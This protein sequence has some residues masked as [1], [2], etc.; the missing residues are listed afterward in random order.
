MTTRCVSSL[1]SV[2]GTAFRHAPF[3]VALRFVTVRR[4][5]Q[6]AGYARSPGDF[7][8]THQHSPNLHRYGPVNLVFLSFR[9]TK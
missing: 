5:S 7:L 6:R 4:H 8:S 1:G 9:I 2:L 3:S